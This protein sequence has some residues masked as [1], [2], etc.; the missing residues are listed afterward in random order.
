MRKE[1]A[2]GFLWFFE[3]SGVTADFCGKL[4]HKLPGLCQAASVE[5]QILSLSGTQG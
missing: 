3:S 5:H 2:A 1:T 4:H